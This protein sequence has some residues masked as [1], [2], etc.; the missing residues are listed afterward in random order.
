MAK[1]DG[2]QKRIYSSPKITRVN[3]ESEEAVLQNC[4]TD[5]NQNVTAGES[6]GECV[7]H[8]QACSTLG[9]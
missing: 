4:K 6:G 8:G 3:L 9:S 5:A 1:R 7:Y 2:I